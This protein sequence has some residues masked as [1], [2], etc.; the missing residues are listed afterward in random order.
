MKIGYA[1]VSTD[2]QNTDLQ[3]DTLKA[4]GCEK[5]FTDKGISGAVQQRPEL[6]K[7]L[8]QAGPD[9]VLMVWKLDRLGRSLPH[10]IEII[11]RLADRKAGFCSISEAIDTTTAGGKLVFHII[12]ALAEFERS[13][14]SER[15]KAGLEAAKRRGKRLGRKPKLKPEQIDH[16]RN[17]VDTGQ[18]TVTGMAEIY[19]VSRVTLHRALR[20]SMV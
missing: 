4:A 1:R 20:A 16:A 11:T 18:E 8:A 19:G 6:D 7:A 3:L 17:M 12:G 14:I 5:I 9:D 13:M 2:D 10:L 15:T